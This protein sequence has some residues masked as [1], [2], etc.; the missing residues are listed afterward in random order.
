MRSC[1]GCGSWNWVACTTLNWRAGSGASHCPLIDYQWVQPVCFPFLSKDQTPSSRFGHRH[2]RWPTSIE[3][4]GSPRPSSAISC[5]GLLESTKLSL[6]LCFVGGDPFAAR[7]LHCVDKMQPGPSS[8][9]DTHTATGWHASALLQASDL[10]QGRVTRQP[11]SA[12]ETRPLC[13]QGLF[14]DKA[15]GG[16]ANSAPSLRPEPPPCSDGHFDP[17]RRSAP[18]FCRRGARCWC[19]RVPCSSESSICSPS[20]RLPS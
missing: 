6:A 15:S 5:L 10:L 11:A 4:E 20:L 3:T 14:A 7:P 17:P 8:F 19:P 16:L 12:L 18:W 1:R 13:R 9:T 2:D